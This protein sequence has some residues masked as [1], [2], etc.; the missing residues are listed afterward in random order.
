MPCLDMPGMRIEPRADASAVALPEMPAKNMLDSTVTDDMPPRRWP[1]MA[2][3]NTM[4]RS[5]MPPTF[6]SVPA[7]RNSGMVRRT[8]WS[9]PAI[10]RCGNDRIIEPFPV[11]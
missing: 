9:T 3:A 8:N 10:I 7:S 11:Q 6:I 5:V 2:R 1:T 4:I